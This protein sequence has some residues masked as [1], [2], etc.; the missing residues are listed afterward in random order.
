MKFVKTL[1]EP[2]KI[3]FSAISNPSSK[4]SPTEEQRSTLQNGAL[5]AIKQKTSNS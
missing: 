4:N 1:N 2:N 5:T 3:P